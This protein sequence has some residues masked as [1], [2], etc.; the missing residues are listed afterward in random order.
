[1]CAAYKTVAVKPETYELLVRLKREHGSFDAAIK[2]L[3]EALESCQRSLMRYKVCNDYSKARAAPNAWAQIFKR[4]G[5][6][7]ALGF[8]LLQPDP[9]DPTVFI[10]DKRKCGE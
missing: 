3:I 1:M 4:E 10:V 2:K 8:S 9:R 6:D 5:V 7:P